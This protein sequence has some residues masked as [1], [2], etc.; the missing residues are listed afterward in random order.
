[1][2]GN[3]QKEQAISLVETGRSTLDLKQVAKEDLV[4]VRC[5]AIPAGKTYLF[6]LI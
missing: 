5:I 2:H 6:P 4:D 3:L 1:V